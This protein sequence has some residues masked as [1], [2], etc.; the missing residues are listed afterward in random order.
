MQRTLSILSLIPVAKLQ[1]MISFIPKGSDLCATQSWPCAITILATL[2]T[3]SL[4]INR[5]QIEQSMKPAVSVPNKN[6]LNNNNNNNNIVIN[7]AAESDGLGHSE[8]F[9]LST[10]INILRRC[11]W[12]PKNDWWEDELD[13]VINGFLNNNNNNNNK[14][15][16][17]LWQKQEPVIPVVV[18]LE[19]VKS[20]LGKAL[21]SLSIDD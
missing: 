5:M 10:R 15:L 11:H 17:R 12:L 7:I 3:S 13:V 21:K 19:C 6:F 14:E 20:N 18:L 1:Y 2:V 9:W 8:W 4:F 16:L